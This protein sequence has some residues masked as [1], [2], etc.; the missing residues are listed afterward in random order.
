MRRNGSYIPCALC[1]KNRYIQPNER[2]ENNFCS[3][4]CHNKYRKINKPNQHLRKYCTT[5][6]KE[7]SVTPSRYE[8]TKTCNRKCWRKWRIRSDEHK[9]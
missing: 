8:R 9:R 3:S 4:G 6:N 7:M 1:G 5:C 2:K